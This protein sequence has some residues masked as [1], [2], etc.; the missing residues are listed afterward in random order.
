M[1]E[2]LINT[3]KDGMSRMETRE[4]GAMC[5]GGGVAAELAHETKRPIIATRNTCLTQF[6]TKSKDVGYEAQGVYG[7]HR[8]SGGKEWRGDQTVLRQSRPG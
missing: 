4:L 6:I 3:L 5:L 2:L 1:R 8:H 7:I